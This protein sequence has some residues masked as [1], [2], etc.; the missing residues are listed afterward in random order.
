MTKKGENYKCV[1]CGNEVT[2][3]TGGG[4]T[5]FCCGKPMEKAG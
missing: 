4:G 1:T 3:T 5:L 2:V